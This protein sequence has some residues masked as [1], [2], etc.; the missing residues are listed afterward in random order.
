MTTKPENVELEEVKTTG[1]GTETNDAEPES[2]HMTVPSDENDF[3]S[4]TN[5]VSFAT[6][7][8]LLTWKNFK[9]QVQRRRGACAF[10]ILF[11]AIIMCII[12]AIRTLP[13]IIDVNCN[14]LPDGSCS[15]F[16]YSSVIPGW[17]SP[18]TTSPINVN[19]EAFPEPYN[20]PFTWLENILCLPEFNEAPNPERNPTQPAMYIGIVTNPDTVDQ[21]RLQGL[22]DI[23][24]DTFI[25]S[26]D[27]TPNDD[28][29]E[30]FNVTERD[31][32]ESLLFSQLINFSEGSAL[33]FFDTNEDL[34]TYVSDKKYAGPGF[35]LANTNKDTGLRPVG[36]AIIINSISEDG[37]VWNYT[38]RFNQSNVPDTKDN[39]VNKFERDS[40]VL[41]FSGGYFEYVT[42][43]FVQMQNWI[44]QG[45]ARYIAGLKNMNYNAFVTD[46]TKGVMPFPFTTYKKDTFWEIISGF[47]FFLIFVMFCYPVLQVLS[48]LISEKADKI[49]GRYYIYIIYI[50]IHIFLLCFEI[51]RGFINDGWHN[52]DLLDIMDFMV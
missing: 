44:D 24:N 1:G 16:Y 19:M 46:T 47:F 14:K 6:K 38:L 20:E 10:K 26:G 36:A 37:L 33:K 15:E 13:D 18:L 9:S 34:N 7:I 49:K 22:L 32:R 35:N 12:G 23:L 4:L 27:M 39:N 48:L 43:G 52:D 50:R 2:K 11:P 31:C 29:P 8:Y 42:F 21:T 41:L 45:I 5:D 3:E 30:L 28:D 51:Y 40:E 25:F 17:I